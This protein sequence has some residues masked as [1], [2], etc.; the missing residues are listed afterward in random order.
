MI[1]Y[2]YNL[3]R[4]NRL[5]RSFFKDNSYSIFKMFI[6]QIG[7][8]IF[9]ISLSFATSNN[10]TLFLLS[11]IFSVCFYMVL[12]YTM[13]WDIGYEEK[14]R[15]DAKRLKFNRFKGLYMSLVANIPNFIIAILIIVGK[16]VNGA[17][18]VFIIGSGAAGLLEGMY[19]GIVNVVF[20]FAPWSYLLIVLPAPIVCT[21]AYIVGVKGFRILPPPKN[22]HN[23]E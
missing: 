15:I 2:A 7:M 22:E 14:V 11:S 16:Y 8:T 21:V 6:N 12:L 13:T 19:M 23:R 3:E 5:M 1:N 18:G 4:A 20:N 17:A 10:N 9:G